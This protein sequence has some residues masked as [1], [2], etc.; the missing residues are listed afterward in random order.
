MLA[1]EAVDCS[2][3]T[4]GYKQRPTAKKIDYEA[5]LAFAPML[6]SDHLPLLRIRTRTLIAA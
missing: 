3:K 1:T 5:T 2:L 6:P 4:P